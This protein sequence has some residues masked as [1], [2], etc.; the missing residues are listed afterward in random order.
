MCVCMG[1]DRRHN[2]LTVDTTV[3]A[4]VDNTEY[5]LNVCRNHVL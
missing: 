2:E 5:E 4:R 3:G 1:E